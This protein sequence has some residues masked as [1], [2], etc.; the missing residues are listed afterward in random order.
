MCTEVTWQVP[1]HIGM[2]TV[3]SEEGCGAEWE[4]DAPPLQTT[5][6]LFQV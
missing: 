3:L 6:W 4:V 5:A 2:L 1:L